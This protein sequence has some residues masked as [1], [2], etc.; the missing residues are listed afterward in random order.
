MRSYEDAELDCIPGLVER[1]AWVLSR[2]TGSLL[3]LQM[4]L[5]KSS[6]ASQQTAVESSEGVPRHGQDMCSHVFV[7][8]QTTG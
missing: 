8:P 6:L 2:D 4:S 3:I 7:A 5:R 1:N